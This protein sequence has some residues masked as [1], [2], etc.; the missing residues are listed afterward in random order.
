MVVI[1][2]VMESLIVQSK[3]PLS[4]YVLTFAEN[5]FSHK[6]QFFFMNSTCVLM[7]TVIV[8]VHVISMTYA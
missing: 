1:F 8:V 5:F 4:K 2:V 7:L 6:K 3:S